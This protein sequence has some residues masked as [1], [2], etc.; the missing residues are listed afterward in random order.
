[1][2]ENW[3]LIVLLVIVVGIAALVG[4]FFLLLI[5]LALWETRHVVEFA[6]PEPGQELPPTDYARNAN[7]TA[8][9]SG[10]QHH[11]TFHHGGSSLFHIRYDFWVSADRLTILVVGGGKAAG[12][13]ANAV[14][15]VSQLSDER[16]LVTT[17]YSGEADLTGLTEIEIW[18]DVG[19]V[20]LIDRHRN[21]V[22]SAPIAITPFGEE[23]LADYMQM[24]QSQVDHLVQRGDARFLDARQSTWKY[25]FK[26]AVHYVYVA[27]FAQ[28]MTRMD[29]ATQVTA[30]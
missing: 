24:R 1:M 26:G 15:L 19:L 20:Y 10:F 2:W 21:R 9:H 28:P 29:R 23:P 7:V 8:E 11:G 14:T 25:T 18:S 3:W 30:K 4:G 27:M 16:Y 13:P 17:D 5:A 12:M 6:V 22:A